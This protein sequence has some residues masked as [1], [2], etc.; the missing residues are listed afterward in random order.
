MSTD[1]AQSMP[2]FDTDAMYKVEVFTDQRTGS[3]R[4]MTPVDA[5]GQPDASRPVRYIGEAQAMTPAGALPLSFELEGS[6]LAE[7][8]AGF[9][10]GAEQAMHETVEELKRMQRESQ[11]SI[12]M[13]GQGNIDLPPGMGR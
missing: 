1:D 11:S 5:D 9:T 12:V 2:N 13:P 6:N 4:R 3:I 8:A 10:A 7:A